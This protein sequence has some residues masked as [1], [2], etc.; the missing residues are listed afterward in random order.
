MTAALYFTK[1]YADALH[2]RIQRERNAT[3]WRVPIRRI[4]ELTCLDGGKPRIFP[5]DN[6]IVLKFMDGSE[7]SFSGDE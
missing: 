6:L 2:E 4:I 7:T 1:T 3:P 5:R